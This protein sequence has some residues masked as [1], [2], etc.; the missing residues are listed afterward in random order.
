MDYLK[1]QAPFWKKEHTPG[2]R[3][4]GRRAC[5][6]RRGARA[7][8]HRRGGERSM[9]ARLHVV[10]VLAVSVGLG[11]RA[12]A[13]AARGVMLNTNVARVFRS[14]HWLV[15][16]RG[17]LPDRHGAGVVR[18]ASPN[19]LLQAAAG[20][21]LPRRPH[22]LL[23]LLR[24]IAVAAA[25]RRLRR[26]GLVHTL[27][28]V[29]GALVLRGP[30]VRPRRGTGSATV[31]AGAFGYGMVTAMFTLGGFRMKPTPPDGPPPVAGTRSPGM[32]ARGTTGW[33]GRAGLPVEA[34]AAAR[35]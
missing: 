35:T 18:R 2:G 33:T 3:P 10:A 23:G 11:R 16:M 32:A 24:R 21:R 27:A 7:L 17:R 14:A 13:L 25:A 26:R 22:D 8:G 20:H 5:R 4:L 28:H 19:D 1:T 30:P 12:G 6:R 15:N 29:A 34:A 31:W 9:S